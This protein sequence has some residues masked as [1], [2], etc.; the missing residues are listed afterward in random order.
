MIKEK[1]A[2]KA[3]RLGM[4]KMRNSNL[5]KDVKEKNDRIKKDLERSA[6][7]QGLQLTLTDASLATASR[8]EPDQFYS[9]PPKN[10]DNDD[11]EIAKTQ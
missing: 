6:K 11:S 10:D 8:L 7:F 1:E 3:D 9:Q 4:L 2:S 5:T